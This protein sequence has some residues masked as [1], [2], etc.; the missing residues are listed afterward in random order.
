MTANE[1]ENEIEKVERLSFQCH[2]NLPKMKMS[3][4]FSISVTGIRD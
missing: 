1:T 2:G 3:M 4:S